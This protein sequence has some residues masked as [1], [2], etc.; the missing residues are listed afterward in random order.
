MARRK[1]PRSQ[2][3]VVSQVG[4]RRSRPWR[5][6]FWVPLLN[7]IPVYF[8]KKE[9][10][11]VAVNSGVNHIFSPIRGVYGSGRQDEAPHFS[12]EGL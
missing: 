11:H 4:K 2:Y 6:S 1:L 5:E 12:A 7:K 8:L 9:F 3:R 10:F